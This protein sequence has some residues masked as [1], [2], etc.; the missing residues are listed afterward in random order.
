MHFQMLSAIRHEVLRVFHCS[1]VFYDPLYNRVH[2][3][4][5]HVSFSNT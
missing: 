3:A 5:I 1:V 2:G 4:T